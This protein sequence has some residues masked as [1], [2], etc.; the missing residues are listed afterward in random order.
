M[1][2]YNRSEGGEENGEFVDESGEDVSGVA[3]I[4][5]VSPTEKGASKVVSLM[6]AC[7][8]RMG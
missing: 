1:F 7:T 5:V 6:E 4:R 8:D 2:C 3:Q